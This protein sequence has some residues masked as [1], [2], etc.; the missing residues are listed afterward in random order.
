MSGDR[1]VALVTGAGTGIGAATARLLAERG[2]RVVICGRRE[3]RLART[4][5]GTD[6]EVVPLDIRDTTAV[7]ALVGGLDRLD[8]VVLNA[9]VVASAPVDGHS[10]ELWRQVLGTNLDAAMSVARASLPLL[11]R[12]HGSLVAVSSVAARRAAVGGAAYS[13]SKAALMMLMA[14]LAVEYGRR[15]VR[16]NTVLP[17]WIRTEMA[18]EE[19]AGVARERGGSVEDAYALATSLVPQGRPGTAAEV[20]EA[21]AFLLSPAASYVTG[22]M[23]TVDGGLAVVD[24]GMATLGD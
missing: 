14:T 3:D 21:I 2:W 17:G 6:M 19:M 18:D 15:G 16:A 22:A 1:S 20:A 7:T 24:P 13:S 23:L 8:G 4:A 9:G 10:D 5:D 11:E 12:G